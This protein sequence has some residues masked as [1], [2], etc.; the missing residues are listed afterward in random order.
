MRQLT[1]STPDGQG[2]AT[3]ESCDT[4]WQM[5]LPAGSYAFHG[6][7]AEAKS[8]IFK[9]IKLHYP[10]LRLGSLDKFDFASTTI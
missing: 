4:P 10:D 6:T 7:A 8:E 3:R 5:N 2:E 1:F 9:A